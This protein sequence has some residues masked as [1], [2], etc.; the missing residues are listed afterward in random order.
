MMGAY[1]VNISSHDNKVTILASGSEVGLALSTQE[2]LKERGVDSKVVSMPCHELFDKQS[3]EYKDQIL[4][5]ESLVV[6]LEAGSTSSWHKYLKKDDIA[7]GIDKFGKS[8]PYQEIY[9]DMNLSS[10][11]IAS[12]IQKKLRK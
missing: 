1:E 4:E 2:L 12:I 8:A 7:I 6:A 9:E 3:E 11:K 5:K 10:S